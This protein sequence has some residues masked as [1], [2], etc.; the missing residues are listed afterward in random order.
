MKRADTVR[1]DPNLQNKQVF[2]SQAGQANPNYG[3]NT[4]APNQINNMQHNAYPPNSQQANNNFI[5]PHLQLGNNN[6]QR[7]NNPAIPA[8][9]QLGNQNQQGNHNQGNPNMS[10]RNYGNQNMSPRNY[11]NQNIQNPYQIT[12]QQNNPQQGLL[13]MVG[14]HANNLYNQQPPHQNNPQ[15][16]LLG[17]VGNHANNIYNRNNVMNG[18]NQ[19]LTAPQQEKKAMNMS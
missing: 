2:Y 7:Q 19:Y 13:G 17:M 3:M 6:N 1:I 10:P 18:Y 4:P 16:G 5:P 11:G 9:L 15:Q 12:P 8:H 14:N